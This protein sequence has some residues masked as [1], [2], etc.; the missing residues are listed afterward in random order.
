MQGPCLSHCY[1][2]SPQTRLLARVAIGYA[3]TCLLYLLLT[4]CMG[5]PL[6]DSF[7]EEQRVHYLSSSIRRAAVFLVSAL[8]SAVLVGVTW[9]PLRPV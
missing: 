8:T 3:T 2:C 4:R 7:T 1:R 5:T 9:K 6:L